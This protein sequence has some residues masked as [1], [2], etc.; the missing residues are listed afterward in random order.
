MARYSQES[1]DLTLASNGRESKQSGKSKLTNIA[2]K[3]SQSISQLLSATETSESAEVTISPLLTSSAEDSPA[4]I[5]AMPA[6]EQES[7]EN[8]AA[9][10]QNMRE[11]FAN[12]DPAT[13]SWRTSQLCFTGEWSE[14]WEIWPRAGMTRNGTAY[15]RESLAPIFYAT[16]CLSLP[17]I[18]S[19]VA[20]DCKGSG[21]NRLERGAN[22]NLRDYFTIIWN[23]LYPPASVVEY[24]MGYP[25]GWTDLKD[26]ETQLSRKSQS[27]SEGE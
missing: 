20:V 5:S 11:S 9:C 24:L 12:Y 3:C 27:G 13:S 6:S 23:T 26:S 8:A 16:E 2:G 17:L 14:F 4:R 21:R 22:N 19:P 25:S 10:G 7:M 18:P 1:E 15:P